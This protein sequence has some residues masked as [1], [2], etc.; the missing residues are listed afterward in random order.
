MFSILILVL[1]AASIV[2]AQSNLRS[3]VFTVGDNVYGQLAV[4]SSGGSRTSPIPLT[5][6]TFNGENI[7]KGD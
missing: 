3:R 1:I 7:V 4:P 6:A 5:D 2:N